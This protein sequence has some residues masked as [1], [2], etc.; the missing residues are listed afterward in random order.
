[1]KKSLRQCGICLLLSLL[2]VAVL[3]PAAI[4]ADGEVSDSQE[5]SAAS[6]EGDAPMTGS[7]STLVTATIAAP[8]EPDDGGS[9]PAAPAGKDNL[10][11][12]GDDT[13]ATAAY[14]AAFASAGLMVLGTCLR[15]R[16]DGRNDIE[17]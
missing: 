13:P 4:A 6:T 2:L 7:A 12:T 9:T 5:V 3:S 1:M 17:P 10:A 16:A 8:T 15:K 14:V 11:K